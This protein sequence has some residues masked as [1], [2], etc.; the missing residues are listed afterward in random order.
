MDEAHFYLESALLKEAS[1]EEQAQAWLWLSEVY[2]DL[3][4]KRECLSQALVIQPT[5]ALARR[6]LA[7][8]DGRL[9]PDEIVDPNKL[10]PRPSEAPIDARATHFRCP[11]CSARLNYAPDGRTLICEFCSHRQ[12]LSANG[13]ADTTDETGFGL[14][15]D[16]I[17]A[18]ATARG[19]LQPVSMRQLRC[20]GCAIEFTLTP[21]TLSV[22][23][24]YCESV[25]VTETAENREIVPPQALIPFLL[26]QDEARQAL[27][28]WFRRYDIAPVHLSP[29]VGIYLPVWTFDVS[30]E[31]KW[32]GQEPQG[33]NWVPVSGNYYVLQDDYLVLAC[34]RTSARLVKTL[35][36]F[37]LGQLV[38]YDAG[39]LADW[40]AERYQLALADAS[41][42][43]RSGIL[44]ELRGHST[45]LTGGRDIRDLRLNSHRMIV[46]SFKQVLLPVW[47]AHYKH[48]ET[49]Y[50]VFINGQTGNVSG[51]RDQ[52]VVNKLISWLRGE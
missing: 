35:Q 22:T 5:S 31:I 16:F 18:L 20:E 32:T 8:L 36:D 33:D 30:G 38:E 14:E 10:K 24:P 50:E 37:D 40:P 27:G 12:T 42:R 47:F 52:R 25:Y 9:N 44:K 17:A 15:Q 6:G 39:Y 41:L 43:A 21:E 29:I 23:C 7:I 48:Q 13:Q 4:E 1:D 49:T 3:A 26:N 28:K 34:K 2:D 45:G 46:E 11:R 51:E 19:H